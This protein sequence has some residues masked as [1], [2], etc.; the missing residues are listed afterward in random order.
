MSVYS[1]LFYIYEE[2][3]FARWLEYIELYRQQRL[4][5]IYSDIIGADGN[6]KKTEGK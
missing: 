6:L 1:G 2:K 5:A 4:I 3:R